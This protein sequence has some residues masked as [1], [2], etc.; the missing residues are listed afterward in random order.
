MEIDVGIAGQMTTKLG[1]CMLSSFKF[2]LLNWHMWPNVKSYLLFQL[3]PFKAFLHT[4]KI[5]NLTD[6]LGT[7]GYIDLPQKT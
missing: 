6:I 5:D 7:Y 3:Y 1:K 4:L 2:Q